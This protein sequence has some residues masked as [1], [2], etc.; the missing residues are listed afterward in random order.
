[1]SETF[2]LD[3]LIKHSTDFAEHIQS[4]LKDPAFWPQFI[5][6]LVVFGIARWLV[7]PLFHRFLNFARKYTQRVYSLK[8]LSNALRDNS[9][10]I[11]WLLLQWIAISVTAYVGL[12]NG[13]LVTV[14]S[15]LAAWILIR[16]AS[17][18]VNNPS[19]SKVIAFSA[20]TVAA[21]NIFGLLD[22]AMTLLDSWAITI[23][24]VRLSPLSVLKIGLSLWFALWLA[25]ALSSL[26]ERRLER[27]LSTSASTR[28]LATKLT[29]ITLVLLAILIALTSVG[30]DLTALAIFSGALGVG[31]GFGLQKIFSNLVSGVI[32]L[33]DKSIKPGDVI[34]L[35]TTF[36]WINHLGLRYASVIT[37]DGMEHLI[38]NEE[39]IVQRV[40][41]WSYSDR[42]VRLKAP[43]G[44]SY[45]SDVR[46]AMKLCVEAA[47]K[48]ERVKADP[49]PRV[50]L[51]GFGDSSVNLEIRLWVDD[52]EKGRANIISEVLLNVWDS[53]HEHGINIPYP[54]R[55]LHVKSVLGV[56]DLDELNL[57]PGIQDNKVSRDEN[58]MTP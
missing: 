49:E 3:V 44:I 40:E 54:Q 19:I 17:M 57:K 39:F 50:Q 5:T 13:A 58:G 20:W 21:L 9:V 53:F 1:M 23:G 16:L 42:L 56:T 31:L 25:N 48:V 12:Y 33:M 11:A 38:P 36:G 7:S 8:R 24:E 37:R 26:L 27:S 14:A 30:I 6:I 29:R 55:D 15:L 10:P 34:S 43:V 45:D 2:N 41:N 47:N 51:M 35:G 4:L 52:P 18:L 46:L 32:L 28:V 22:G